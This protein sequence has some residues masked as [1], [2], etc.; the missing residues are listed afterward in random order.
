MYAEATILDPRY[1]KYIFKED[2]NYRIAINNL[3]KKLANTL[4]PAMP[5][6][7]SIPAPEEPTT[8]LT[9]KKTSIW[10]DFDT[11]L[12]QHLRPQNQTAAG[13]KELD[14]YLE[15]EM[16]PRTIKMVGRT[17]TTLPTSTQFYAQKIVCHRHFCTM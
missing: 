4:V 9:L 11:E 6:T 3:R 15:D 7:R 1:K 10:D 14:K 17:K 16:L 12:S 2:N 13:I 5:N 8:T